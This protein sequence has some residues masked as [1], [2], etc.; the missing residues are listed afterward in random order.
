M[1]NDSN[2]WLLKETPKPS[3]NW[4]IPWK[5]DQ[6]TLTS[7]KRTINPKATQ[8]YCNLRTQDLTLKNSQQSGLKRQLNPRTDIEWVKNNCQI[9]KIH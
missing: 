9:E 1:Q 6:I 2:R 4:Q 3:S 8:R 7:C 5:I